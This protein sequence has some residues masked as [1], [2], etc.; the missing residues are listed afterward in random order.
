MG[1]QLFMCST[2]EGWGLFHNA[3][4]SGGGMDITPMIFLNQNKYAAFFFDGDVVVV[5][6]GGA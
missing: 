1:V 3:S 6:V 4:P 5:V 2:L